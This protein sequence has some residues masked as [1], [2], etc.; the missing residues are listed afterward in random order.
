MIRVDDITRAEWR[1]L[2]LVAAALVLSG[3]G[4]IRTEPGRGTRATGA[5][6]ASCAASIA[7][8]HAALAGAGGSPAETAAA[9]AAHAAAMSEYHACLA[10]TAH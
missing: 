5:P 2:T 8:A 10:N 4:V 6:I 1:A 7:R 3:C 9:H